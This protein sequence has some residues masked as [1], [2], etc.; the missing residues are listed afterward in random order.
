MNNN[1]TLHKSATIL[2]AHFG[3]WVIIHLPKN[4]SKITVY[5]WSKKPQKFWISTVGKRLLEFFYNFTWTLKKI[6]SARSIWPI[7]MPLTLSLSF[8][9]VIGLMKTSINYSK[10]FLNISM[11]TKENSAQS[12]NSE[13]KFKEDNLDGVHVTPKDSGKRM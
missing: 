2:S 5:H 10:L 13:I 3:F 12:R 8:K 4:I 1:H 11:K 7:S 6:K 9:T